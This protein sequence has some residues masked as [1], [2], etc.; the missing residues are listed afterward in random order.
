MA[1]SLRF[2]TAILL[3][4]IITGFL[5]HSPR[6]TLHNRGIVLLRY[7]NFGMMH[8]YAAYF[9]VSLRLRIGITGVRSGFEFL[10]ITK[11]VSI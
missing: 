2:A 6:V 7:V 3:I 9:A 8:F 4:A 1:R 11:S 5:F 10:I